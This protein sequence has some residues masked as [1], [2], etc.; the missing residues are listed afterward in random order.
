M[1]YLIKFNSFLDSYVRDV[2]GIIHNNFTKNKFGEYICGKDIFG[3][4]KFGSGLEKYILSSLDIK[5]N[6]FQQDYF[7]ILGDCYPIK[8]ILLELDNIQFNNNKLKYELLEQDIKIDL[9]SFNRRVDFVFNRLFKR[10]ICIPNNIFA[11]SHDRLGANTL[12]S[13][14]KYIFGNVN[15]KDLDINILNGKNRCLFDTNEYIESSIL[16]KSRINKNSELKLI[17]NNIRQY[18]NECTGM[19]WSL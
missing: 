5:T 15:C 7:F 9:K 11:I 18:V 6:I 2:F 12:K 13:I 17:I 3:S 16:N 14:L 8:N 10:K 1:I 19:N 4:N